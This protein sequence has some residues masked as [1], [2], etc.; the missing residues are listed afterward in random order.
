MGPPGGLPP[1]GGLSFGCRT[2][3]RTPPPHLVTWTP[4]A[5]R[6]PHHPPRVGSHH[7]EGRFRAALAHLDPPP[8]VQFRSYRTTPRA[9]ECT[10]PVRWSAPI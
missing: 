10:P 7:P 2:R 1:S 6:A 9:V 5:G 3:C 4:R 8:R